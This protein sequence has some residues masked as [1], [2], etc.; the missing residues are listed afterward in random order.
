MNYLKE[1]KDE[2]KEVLAKDNL[3]NII[4][5]NDGFSAT[6][7]EKNEKPKKTKKADTSALDKLYEQPMS[8]DQIEAETEERNR[9]L[10]E[11]FANQGNVVPTEGVAVWTGEEE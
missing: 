11:K 5:N 4:I 9:K 3:A 7:Y 2:I 10:R 1:L 6:F 8:Q